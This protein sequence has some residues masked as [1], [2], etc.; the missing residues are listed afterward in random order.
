MKRPIC[1]CVAV[2]LLAAI[3]ATA[4][5]TGTELDAVAIS[6]E[7]PDLLTN[8]F[9]TGYLNG[10]IQGFLDTTTDHLGIPQNIKGG[11]IAEMV[12][13]YIRETFICLLTSYY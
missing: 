3:P 4:T 1:I 10:F 7:N 8:L 2:I 9:A 11:D 13:K 5:M 12:K 6:C